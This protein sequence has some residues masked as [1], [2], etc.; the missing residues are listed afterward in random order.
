MDTFW[1]DLRYGFRMLAKEPAFTAVAVVALAL[2]IGANTAIFSVVNGVLLR[3]LPYPSPDRLV[4]V[5]DLQPPNEETPASYPE[6]ASWSEQKQLFDE[7][8]CYFN[9]SYTLTG[10]T[11]PEQVRGMRVSASLF[12]LM[13]TQ[14]LLGRLLLPQDEQPDSERVV[15]ISYGL[16]KRALGGDPNGVGRTL[17]LND[18]IYTV[19]GVLPADFRFIRNPEVWAG[20]RLDA[21][22]AP[23]GLH[24]LQVLARL[25]P[26]LSLA[27]AR[28]EIEP[29]AA[30]LQKEH[31]RNHRINLTGLREQI[32]GDSRTLLLIL[33]CAVGFVLLIACANIAN[34]LLARAADRRREIAV[35]LA[36]GASKL[37]IV[38]QLLTEHLLL[39]LLGGAVGIA[40]AKYGLRLLLA[41][42]QNTIPR[43][44]EVNIDS[45][46][47]LFSVLI[48][49][50]T[51]VIF[52]L[53]P[54]LEAAKTT[55][56]DTLKEGGR[57]GSGGS[58]RFR[59][60]SALVISEVAISFVLLV[61][62]GLLVASFVRLTHEDKGFDPSR[63]LTFEV[64][65]PVAKYRGPQQQIAF[66]REALNRLRALPGVE[67]AGAIN[68]LPLGGG[69]V[70]GGFTIE[71]RPTGPRDPEPV[72]EKRMISAGY[73]AT[74]RIPL[75][76]G[77]F[78]NDRDREG[79][80]QVAIVNEALARRYF[81]NEDPIGKRIDFGWETTGSQEIVGVAGN[82][83]GISLGQTAQPAIYLPFTQRATN[84]LVLL[85]RTTLDP[86]AL[87]SAAREAI[88][89]VD[90]NQPIS[91]IRTL[92]DVVYE[93]A[94]KPRFRTF[95]FAVFAS[96]AL[97]L[98]TIGLYG[99][100]A[101]SV[102][103]RTHE[104]GIR[105]ALGAQ[106]SDVLRMVVKEGMLLVIIGIVIGLA[107]AFAVTR[108]LASLLY[109]VT[110]TDPVT[111]VTLSLLMI[112]VALIACLL[113]ARRALRV[114]P[115]VALRYE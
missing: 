111:F 35:R 96:I 47:L 102:T 103:Q 2:G 63:V 4:M 33:Q 108:V 40:L 44:T 12:T 95:L 19:V 86:S 65:L 72:S 98:A 10:G 11:L 67:E 81:P 82:V 76:Q 56:S 26:G 101:F 22:R 17:R 39:S 52:G 79:A 71:G 89:G 90:Q 112:G 31:S 75:L 107:A 88:S 43:A 20:H 94:G 14:P 46:V 100:M 115:M 73:F 105:V 87:V 80:P 7:A 5:W 83:R 77:R 113:P 29:V 30:Q 28:K 59:L 36:L 84:D 24:F 70:N 15:V 6:F 57:T 58:R 68:E 69:D 23:A 38:R 1:Q 92:E 21:Q 109:G 104:I 8:A 74:M 85:V 45:R 110:P 114:D 48:A 37:R 18:Q 50:A 99:V 64:S 16:W 34:L 42:E 13:G 51:G 55:L 41:L 53:A 54:A 32:I 78:F 62:A 97:V 3:P 9:T 25:R 60:R 27:Q 66:F 91:N 61:G 106:G 93:S 49:I